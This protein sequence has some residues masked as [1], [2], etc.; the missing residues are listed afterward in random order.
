MGSKGQ[1]RKSGVK[2]VYTIAF[3]SS[4]DGKRKKMRCLG[5]IFDQAKEGMDGCWFIDVM[6]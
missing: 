6:R 5:P 3:S 1:G 2:W 4:S